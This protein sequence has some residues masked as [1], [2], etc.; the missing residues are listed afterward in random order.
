M[1][2]VEDEYLMISGI[3]HFE[4]CPRQWALIHIEQQWEENVKTIQGNELHKKADQPFLKEKRSGT[5]ISRAMPVHSHE[6]KIT[7]VCDVVEFIRDENG[8]NL[9]KY[10]GKYRV[11]P[12]EYKRGAPK[13]HDADILQLVAQ[14]ICLEEM[15]VCEIKE[16]FL[17]YNEIKRREKIIITPELRETLR[18]KIDRMQELYARKHTPKVKTGNWCRNCSLQNVCL[19]KLMNTE[20]AK[21]YI[22]KR[23]S[24]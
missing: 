12:V 13:K 16:G 10:E 20:S 19:P 7:G 1:N 3:Q 24:E 6:L 17:Y 18:L 9:N 23:L 8:I 14:A 21:R 11:Q 2:Y 4:F 22:E 5:I 15:L